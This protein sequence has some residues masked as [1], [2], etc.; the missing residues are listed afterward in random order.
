MWGE[1]AGFGVDGSDAAGIRTLA[2][3]ALRRDYLG[4]TPCTGQMSQDTGALWI[5]ETWCLWP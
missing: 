1:V 4:P 5:V 3:I 2:K